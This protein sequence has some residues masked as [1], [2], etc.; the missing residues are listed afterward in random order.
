[1]QSVAIRFITLLALAGALG[2]AGA[3]VG[4]SGREMD[5]EPG[6]DVAGS[7]GART[8][9]T[10]RDGVTIDQIAAGVTL[11][12]V[13]TERGTTSGQLVVP[14][15]A[16]GTGVPVDL[17]GTGELEGNTVRFVQAAESFVGRIPFLASPR[18]LAGEATIGGTEFPV[19]LTR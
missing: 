14:A 16:G 4:P 6:M 18:R 15:D 8:I 10:A 11:T 17:T 19:V 7:H 12:L 13:R 1:M 2:C 3:D 9:M 5:T